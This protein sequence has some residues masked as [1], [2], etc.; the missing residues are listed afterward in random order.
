MDAV[1]IQ[2][3]P[4]AG[5][6]NKKWTTHSH[7]KKLPTMTV[8]QHVQLPTQPSVDS[9]RSSVSWEG[10]LDIDPS[11]V[12]FA[13]NELIKNLFDMATDSFGLKSGTSI[14]YASTSEVESISQG[15][16]GLG[17]P[18][19]YHPGAVTA[20]FDLLPAISEANVSVYS[21]VISI[22]FA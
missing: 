11:S 21:E 6:R 4:A 1:N 22:L 10:S 3:F 20:A 19:I 12:L 2:F 8:T 9:I 17:I 14:I 16:V 18:Y 5:D 15:R 7:E 13:A